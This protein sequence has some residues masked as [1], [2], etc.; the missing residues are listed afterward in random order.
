MEEVKNLVEK[1]VEQFGRIDILVNNAATNPSM[2]S[3]LDI[4]DKAWDSI[5]NLNAKGLFFLSQATVARVMKEKGG[6]TIINVSS[7]A[8]ISPDILPIYSISKAAVNMA[9]KVMARSS[10]RRTTSGPTRSPRAL[11]GPI[12][13]NPF[14]VTPIS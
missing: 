1:V 5:M 10:G 2:A 13:V 7:V 11:Q 8:G 12:S 9:T 3:A 6:G 4:E 14:G